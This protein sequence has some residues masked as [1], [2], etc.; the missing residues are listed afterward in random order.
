MFYCWPNICDASPTLKHHC[1]NVT[2]LLGTS[3]PHTL[4]LS[5]SARISMMSSPTSLSSFTVTLYSSSLNSGSLISRG[6]DTVTCTSVVLGVGKA[7]SDAR[8]VNCTTHKHFSVSVLSF[9]ARGSTLDVRLWRLQTSDSDVWCR[10]PHCK[11]I[12]ISYG[13]RPI[14]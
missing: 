6:T 12:H 8:T 11:S 9:T 3:M 1:F 13:S 4:R 14:T 7:W 5:S 2:C 10:S